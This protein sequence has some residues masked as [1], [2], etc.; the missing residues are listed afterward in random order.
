MWHAESHLPQQHKLNK[1]ISLG[2][3]FDLVSEGLLLVL[4][5]LR[6][7]FMSVCML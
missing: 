6:L 1:T 2:E 3:L 5:A 4:G 7:V